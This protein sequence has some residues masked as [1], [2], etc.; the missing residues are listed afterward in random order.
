MPL[1]GEETEHAIYEYQRTGPSGPSVQRRCAFCHGNGIGST[2][3]AAERSPRQKR[4][5]NNAER[6]ENNEQCAKHQS[7]P[8]TRLV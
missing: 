4:K 7:G 5:Q 3:R 2:R 8:S 1:A 6:S